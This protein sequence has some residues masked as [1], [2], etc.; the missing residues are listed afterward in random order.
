MMFQF[1]ICNLCFSLFDWLLV[2]FPL[3]PASQEVAEQS[4]LSQE[5]A[6][7][8]DHQLFIEVSDMLHYQRCG[9]VTQQIANP[10]LDQEAYPKPNEAEQEQVGNFVFFHAS[11]SRLVS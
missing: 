8:L 3:S 11:S 9:Q 1:A 6:L 4:H 2:C 5:E 7:S 10:S